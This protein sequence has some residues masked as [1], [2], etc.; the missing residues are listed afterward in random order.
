MALHNRY[1]PL[2]LHKLCNGLLGTVGSATLAA[3]GLSF[4]Q[5]DHLLHKLSVVLLCLSVPIGIVLAMITSR[6]SIVEHCAG[7]AGY[8]ELVEDDDEKHIHKRDT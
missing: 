7:G 5:P 8:D 6:F 4:F 1:L 3:V 2:W